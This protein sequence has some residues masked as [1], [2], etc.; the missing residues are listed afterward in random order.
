MKKLFKNKAI[1]ERDHEIASLKLDLKQA[2]HKINV[3]TASNRENERRIA[4]A[5][6]ALFGIIQDVKIIGG[7]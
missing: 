6:Q 7:P 2:Y 1:D 5:R 4:K 3:L